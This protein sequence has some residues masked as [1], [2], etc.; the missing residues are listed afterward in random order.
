M[1]VRSMVVLSLVS[2]LLV[3]YI[4]QSHYIKMVTEY[5]FS[6]PSNLKQERYLKQIKGHVVSLNSEKETFIFKPDDLKHKICVYYEAENIDASVL[7]K[8]ILS[9]TG[10][11]IELDMNERQFRGTHNAYGFDYQKYLYAM[12][13]VGQYH[14]KSYKVNPE[15]SKLLFAVFNLNRIKI[16]RYAETHFPQRVSEYFNA[17]VLGSNAHLSEK[18]LFRKLGISHIF[19]I[20]G[21]HFGLIYAFLYKIIRGPRSFK[22]IFIILILI[23]YWGLIG[24]SYSAGRAVFLVIYIEIS[25]ILLRKIDLI[26]AVAFTNLILLFIF[27]NAVLAVSYQLSFIAYLLIAYV[28]QKGFSHKPKN[29]FLENLKLALFIQV[30]FLPIQLHYF[31]E[32][33]L[34]AFFPNVII[35]P[36]ISALFPFLFLMPILGKPLFI[37]M[38]KCLYGVE[39]LSKQMPQLLVRGQLFTPNQFRIIAIATLFFGLY[40]S[41]KISDGLILKKGRTMITSLIILSMLLSGFHFPAMEVHFFD[42]GHGDSA[43]IRHDHVNILIDTGDQ[44]TDLTQMLLKRDIYKIDALILSHA[45][46]DHV[47][48][49]LKLAE[50]FDINQIYCNRETLEVIKE[51]VKTD[52]EI[53]L[54]ESTMEIVMDGVKLTLMPTVAD[55]ANDNAIAVWYDSEAIKGVFLGDMS[56]AVYEKLPAVLSDLDFIKIAHHGSKTGLSTTFLDRHQ[57]QYAIISHDEKYLMPNKSIIDLL[58]KQDIEIYE[59]YNCGEIILTGKGIQCYLDNNPSKNPNRFVK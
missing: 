9:H 14:L 38:E 20:S 30:F 53:I 37:L 41:C 12:N 39:F 15:D 8:D 36:M 29:K 34:L 43:L 2:T 26:S 3:H 25:R 23:M 24:F 54:V 10:F 40:K 58:K 44:Y 56:G 1:I 33:N 27:P 16:I 47:G 22:S 46:N 11:E 5:R 17:L 59:T 21:M 45:H 48:G 13:V 32:V 28:Y 51:T 4:M 49:V 52:S 50:T 35:V 7:E 31:N 18:D 19:A 42:V 57:I 6:T 55:D